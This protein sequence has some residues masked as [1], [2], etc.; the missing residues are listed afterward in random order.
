MAMAACG[1]ASF[2]DFLDDRVDRVD[3]GGCHA[4]PFIGKQVR[5][6]TAHAAGCS[7]DKSNLSGNGSGQ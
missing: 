3:V 1:V 5:S 2:G 6:G 7:S 4:G